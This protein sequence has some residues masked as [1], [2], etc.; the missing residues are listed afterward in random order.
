MAKVDV[1]SAFSV[2]PVH[3]NDCMLL[4][5]MWDGHYYVD[6][7]LPFG[8]RSAPKIFNALA[9]ALQWNVMQNGVCYLKHCLEDFVTVGRQ[10][11]GEC[12]FNIEVLLSCCSELDVPIAED[13]TVWPSTVITFLGIKIDSVA[14]ELRLPSEKLARIS[15][16]LHSW[17][18]HRS[19][20]KRELQ[21]LAGILEDAART[22]RPGKTFLRQICE[23]IASLA[24]PHHHIKLKL[25]CSK[26]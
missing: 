6:G 13:K 19:A 7:V 8:L 5:M 24:K 2:V 23:A 21:S 16:S 14:Q 18:N 25:C 10:N 26:I 11:S 1:K 3:P 9:D 4:G 12:L 22:V 20:T 17:M 15:A